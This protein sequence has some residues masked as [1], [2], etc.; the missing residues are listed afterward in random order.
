MTLY[1]DWYKVCEA[2]AKRIGAEL[3]F[4]NPDSFGICTK[5]E[6]LLH[7]YADEL[8]EMLATEHWDEK[9]VCCICGK[10]FYGCGNNPDP[11]V[12]V[13][14]YTDPRC[15]DECNDTIVVPKRLEQVF[16]A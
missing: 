15:C 6:K 8:A 9:H 3:L 1:E 11:V 2:F 10:E 14:A 5:D 4:V 7:I 12:D 13:R 16:G